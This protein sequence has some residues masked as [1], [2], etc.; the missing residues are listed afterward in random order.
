MIETTSLPL[1][2][3]LE[4][5]LEGLIESFF[6]HWRDTL[7]NRNDFPPY[8]ELIPAFS[9]CELMRVFPKK[10]YD[11]EAYNLVMSLDN[12]DGTHWVTYQ[13]TPESGLIDIK[14]L[15]HH[16]ILAEAVGE[17]VVWLY[18]EGLLR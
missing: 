12:S 18:K 4:P 3:K 10:A 8:F 7:L 6:F 11:P 15:T 17:M 13:R 5:I 2:K 14:K 9:A 16:A 1:S